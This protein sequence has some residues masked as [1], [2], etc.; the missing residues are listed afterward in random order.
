[1]KVRNGIDITETARMRKIIDEGNSAFA[2]RVFTLEEREYCSS[3]ESDRVKAERYAARYAAKEA[4]AKALGTGIC[5]KGIG[6]Q[7]IEVTK[8][9]AGAPLL[10][11]SGKALDRAKEIKV[12]SMAL[13]I[14]HEKDYAAAAV[15]LLTDEEEF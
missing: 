4:A 15:T 7:D 1:M 6:F 3:S 8:D 14:T 2:D 9:E 11:L 13:S 5:T 12:L 10:R